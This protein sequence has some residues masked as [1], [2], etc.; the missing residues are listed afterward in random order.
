MFCRCE[1]L[2]PGADESPDSGTRARFVRLSQLRDDFAGM[3][4]LGQA[5]ADRTRN[6]VIDHPGSV[7]CG[8]ERLGSVGTHQTDNVVFFLFLD[9]DGKFK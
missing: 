1:K 4:D 9:N 7:G 2:H 3:V 5:V 8:I 6:K